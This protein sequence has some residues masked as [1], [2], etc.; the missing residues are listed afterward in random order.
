MSPPGVNKLDLLS[1]GRE[2]AKAQSQANRL[3]ASDRASRTRIART[4]RITRARPGPTQGVRRPARFRPDDVPRARAVRSRRMCWLCLARARLAGRGALLFLP[5]F[6]GPLA[7]DAVLCPPSL[8]TI[9]F[10]HGGERS[11]SRRRLDAGPAPGTET[12]AER[13]RATVDYRYWCRARLR[14]RSG[15]DLEIALM[16]RMRELLAAGEPLHLAHGEFTHAAHLV[17]HRP[18][19]VRGE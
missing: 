5:L 3:N 4:G 16:Y 11:A 19:D 13:P 8:A 15:D 6:P 9:T 18:G 1:D 14:G 17:A 7:P 12:R 2:G 10:T